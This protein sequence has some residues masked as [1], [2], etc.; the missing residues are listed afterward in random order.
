MPRLLLSVLI[1]TTLTLLSTFVGAR[2][3]TATYPDIMG[4]EK[5]CTVAAS[6]WPLVFVRDYTGMSVVDTADIM[7]V[8][9]AA[10]RFDWLPFLLNLFFWSV[11]SLAAI[12][13][14]WGAGRAGAAP[15]S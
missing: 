9:F 1:G 11:L 15:D 7:E 2:S 13:F 8:W 6:G 5:S 14:M 3:A 12:A 10:D 4:C